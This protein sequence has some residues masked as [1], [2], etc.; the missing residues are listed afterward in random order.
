MEAPLGRSN[1]SLKPKAA[2]KN[3]PW[4]FNK[5]NN[6]KFF[7]PTWVWLNGLI[8]QMKFV[9]GDGNLFSLFSCVANSSLEKGW[10]RPMV[11]CERWGFWNKAFFNERIRNL[12]LILF[13]LLYRMASGAG[14]ESVFILQTWQLFY[15]SR[16]WIDGEHGFL[17][18]SVK[19]KK[20]T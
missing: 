1:I 5:S 17:D 13:F 8:R 3:P 4:I 2:G 18:V 15:G 9:G 11:I 14:F 7:H 12:L 6:W 16:L 20:A 19:G 10:N